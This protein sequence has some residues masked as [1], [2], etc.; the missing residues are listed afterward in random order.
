MSDL[1]RQWLRQGKASHLPV[2]MSR[3]FGESLLQRPWAGS[4]LRWAQITPHVTLN[5][6]TATE[7]SI[8]DWLAE[9]SIGGCSHIALCTSE[10]EP[11]L[12][13]RTRE[14][15]LAL[16]EL[17]Y[18]SGATNFCFGVDA[19]PGVAV[20]LLAPT[21]LSAHFD[22]LLQWGPGDFLAG[23]A[24]RDGVTAPRRPR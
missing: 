1:A 6:A 22:R 23:T 14:G 10:E 15:L 5:L 9:A 20:G 13:V 7:A 3:A 16:D 4:G 8:L 24:W 17:F 21:D 11:S 12:L 19:D 18:P 2:A